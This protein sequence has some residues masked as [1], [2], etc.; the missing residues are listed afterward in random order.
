MNR[1]LFLMLPLCP[2]GPAIHGL[3]GAVL[4][5]SHPQKTLHKGASAAPPAVPAPPER[6]GGLRQG[7]SCLTG[8]SVRPAAQSASLVAPFG[9]P[10]AHPAP[11]GWAY[12]LLPAWV[13]AGIA[14]AHVAL[15]GL[16]SKLYMQACRQDELEI[17]LASL[18]EDLQ[19]LRQAIAT[20]VVTQ[21]YDQ[22]HY[23]ERIRQLEEAGVQGQQQQK[24]LQAQVSQLAGELAGRQE[25]KEE[26]GL[27]GGARVGIPSSPWPD[28]QG[29]YIE[30][31]EKLEAQLAALQGSLAKLGQS[32][33]PLERHQEQGVLSQ[34]RM[35]DQALGLLSGGPSPHQPLPKEKEPSP[36]PAPAEVQE[37]LAPCQPAAPQQ[38]TKKERS[39]KRQRRTRAS[40]CALPASS[41]AM[42]VRKKTKKK[43][44]RKTASKTSKVRRKKGLAPRKRDA[45]RQ[46]S[47]RNAS[48]KQ[49]QRASRQPACKTRK[50][51]ASG[52]GK[53]RAPSKRRAQ[54]SGKHII[55]KKCKA[56]RDKSALALPCLFSACREGDLSEVASFLDHCSDPYGALVAMS[57]QEAG[58]T[59]LHL[60]VQHLAFHVVDELLGRL[61]K[62]GIACNLPDRAEEA[63]PLHYL[64]KG[65]QG[66]RVEEEEATRLFIMDRLLCSGAD[67]NQVTQKGVP[68]LY[69]ALKQGQV[70]LSS[71][72]L[73]AGARYDLPIRASWE[74]LRQGAIG[75]DVLA[76][77]QLAEEKSS[78][79]VD[80]MLVHDFT[81]R[82]ENPF[83]EPKQR[84]VDWYRI[85]CPEFFIGIVL[86]CFFASLFN[87]QDPACTLHPAGWH[88]GPY[89][90]GG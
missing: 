10:A 89:L 2:L 44:P 18:G 33:T 84:G 82:G 9:Q 27:Q 72:L 62:A 47:P 30:K 20:Q 22:A 25:H 65:R 16:G 70:A 85:C 35:V 68:P 56:P 81:E 57:P 78:A 4:P 67:V 28:G 51:S 31:I 43:K 87:T 19:T 11:V 66:A 1:Y 49:G 26:A 48:A 21:E 80:L 77:A 14:Y 86:A 40:Q 42:P 83:Q 29:Y 37:T 24:T 71:K 38:A 55:S 45:H 75:W 5:V 63:T 41:E 54:P 13:E 36:A 76:Y 8:Q 50:P 34:E 64:F 15:E 52:Q 74:G 58:A 3:T 39:P 61:S 6:G 88:G 90:G 59:A 32:V 46:A 7:A 17:G 53:Q 12:W 23:A 79:L 73:R 60:A 69:Y